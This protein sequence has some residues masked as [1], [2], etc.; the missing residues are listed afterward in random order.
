MLT[1]IQKWGNSLALRIPK[2]FAEEVGLASETAVEIRVVE[3]DTLHR[4]K[5]SSF[6]KTPMSKPQSQF[7]YGFTSHLPCARGTTHNPLCP[8]TPGY[9]TSCTCFALPLPF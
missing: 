9:D 1:K 7:S 4:L 6:L 3:G 2:A 8:S 5:S